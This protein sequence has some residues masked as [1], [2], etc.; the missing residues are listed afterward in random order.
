MAR[1]TPPQR[2]AIR[3][4]TRRREPDPSEEAGELNIVPLLDVVINLMLF[5]LATSAA[6]IATAEVGVELPGVCRGA[7]CPEPRE[8]IQ[9]SVTVADA[10]I[11]VAAEGG[12]LAPGCDG[13]GGAGAT[14]PGRDWAA[15]GACLQRVHE[16]FPDETGLTLSADPSVPY[17]DLVRAMDEAHGPPEAPRFGEIRLS[18]GV[19]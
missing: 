8:S 13:V 3:R 18:A 11:Y 6:V 4:A 7:G 14:V 12:R 16:R 17:E 19:R 9:L 15:L 5:L 10:G 1:L 2:A